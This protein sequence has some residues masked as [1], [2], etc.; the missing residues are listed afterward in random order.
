VSPIH[1]VVFVV[2]PEA[3]SLDF[4]GPLEV[5]DSANRLGGVNGVNGV[6]GVNYRARFASVDGGILRTSSGL[7]VETEPLSSIR[8]VDTLIVVGGLGTD[9]ALK[10]RQLLDG[11]KRL[12]RRSARVASVC[13]GSF[14]LAE[15]GLLDGL[16][17]TTHWHWASTFAERYPVVDVDPSAIFVRSGRIWTSAGVTS[18]IDLALALVSDDHGTAIA[19]SVA[20]Y[21]VVYLQ[22]PGGQSQYTG[23]HVEPT[24]MPTEW[25]D[26][27]DWMR[28]H[29]ANDLSVS[30]LA[31]RMHLSE[32]QFARLFVESFAATPGAYVE[33]LR[34]R[35]A[36]DLLE[37][38][39][40]LTQVIA[41]E[42]G[43]GT[44]ETMHRVFRRRLDTTPSAHRKHFAA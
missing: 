15:L 12:A 21:L 36:C 3:Q 22:R 11:V 9:R 19:T 41:A 17:A 1:H 31:L 27:L 44:I 29:L 23:V 6:T 33:T 30:A 43:F 32:R 13:T 34:L 5:F 28:S 40:K 7:C 18:G 25:T 4:V 10:D 39:A 16:R 14:L 42:C 24:T 37:R 35:A 26:L 8:R 38:S 2:F 20:R